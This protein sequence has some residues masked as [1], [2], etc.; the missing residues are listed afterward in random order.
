MATWMTSHLPEGARVLVGPGGWVPLDYG[1]GTIGPSNSNAGPVG[2]PWFRYQ[3]RLSDRARAPRFDFE[4][5]DWTPRGVEPFA[6]P[7]RARRFLRESGADYLVI[8]NSDRVRVF[9]GNVFEKL[10]RAAEQLGGL[11]HVIHPRGP[12]GERLYHDYDHSWR[13]FAR[14][15]ESD[16]LGPTVEIWRLRR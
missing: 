11:E 5:I 7:A 15:L 12:R 3:R 9:E 10:R 2:I 8:E 14:T 16:A 6:S 13:M 1:P 4:L